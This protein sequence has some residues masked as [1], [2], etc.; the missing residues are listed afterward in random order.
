MTYWVGWEGCEELEFVGPL[1]AVELWRDALTLTKLGPEGALG[2]LGPGPPP[3]PALGTLGPPCP[4]LLWSG[5][6]LRGRHTGQSL[7]LQFFQ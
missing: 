2:R 4:G 6:V 1:E 3:G 7:R 5:D